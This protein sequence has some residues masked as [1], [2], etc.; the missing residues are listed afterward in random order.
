MRELRTKNI[1][2]IKIAITLRGEVRRGGVSID[3]TLKLNNRNSIKNRCKSL[4]NKLANTVERKDS[5][6]RQIH[7]RGLHSY[8]DVKMILYHAN[9]L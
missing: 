5:L 7:V 4:I 3:M 1:M 6:Q 9:G 2:L 8:S